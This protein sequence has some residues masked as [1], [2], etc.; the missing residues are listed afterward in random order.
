MEYTSYAAKYEW[1]CLPIPF[2]GV[3][4]SVEGISRFEVDI[5]YGKISVVCFY[6]VHAIF[7]LA[8]NK[9]ILL[10]AMDLKHKWAHKICH[11]VFCWLTL[12]GVRISRRI[13]N[14][15]DFGESWAN[16]VKWIAWSSF[17]S[18]SEWFMILARRDVYIVDIQR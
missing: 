5:E 4:R 10:S 3:R 11:F 6:C 13:N 17:A 12:L 1:L 16:K 7:A 15:A 18:R 2:V 14:V 9:C 8:Y